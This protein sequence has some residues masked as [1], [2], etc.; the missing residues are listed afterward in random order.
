M[1]QKNGMLVERAKE[2]GI[3]P[4]PNM[5]SAEIKEAFDKIKM[6]F[7]N[8]SSDRLAKYNIN[9][10][11]YYHKKYG[12]AEDRK[13][14]S[15]EYK[16][17][18]EEFVNTASENG[19]N[20]SDAFW[21]HDFTTETGSIVE[22]FIVDIDIASPHFI[23]TMKKLD[24]FCE[25]YEA[26]YK[27][28]NPDS[29]NR[30]DTMNIYMTQSI[31][32]EIA[33]EVVD[34]VQPCL[35]ETLHNYLDG[36]PLLKNGQEIK[37]IKIGPEPVQKGELKKKTEKHEQYEKNMKKDLGGQFYSALDSAFELK[38]GGLAMVFHNA[39]FYCSFGQR[40]AAMEAIELAYYL[41]GQEDK[42][43]ALI[44]FQDGQPYTKL[45]DVDAKKDL[46]VQNL[47]LSE[48]LA[49]LGERAQMEAPKLPD[50]KMTDYEQQVD[51]MAKQGKL[52]GAIQKLV[53]NSPEVKQVGI[54]LIQEVFPC[55]ARSQASFSN[56]HNLSNGMVPPPRIPNRTEG[57]VPSFQDIRRPEVRMPSIRRP[58]TSVGGR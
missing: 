35:N 2:L 9:D 40:T 11:V 54:Q 16:K 23:D 49:G 50:N 36:Q 55:G 57:A 8:R 44:Q 45:L 7:V 25:K 46:S 21:W 47:S 42:A 28:P 24:T 41:G 22:R 56:T 48:R 31:T 30:S 51:S 15:F 19:R 38:S 29:A 39:S 53:E 27:I 13:N 12:V 26:A 4:N 1:Q 37:G 3:E 17:N 33:S 34:I 14:A 6:S 5:S 52:G 18:Y 43:P 20:Q 58:I 32:P 10:L